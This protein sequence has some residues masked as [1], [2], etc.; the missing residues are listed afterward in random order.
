[1]EIKWYFKAYHRMITYGPPLIIIGLMFLIY[2][3]Y[4]IEYIL[5]LMRIDPRRRI[6]TN[7]YIANYY[8][9]N[10]SNVGLGLFVVLNWCFF[11]MIVSLTRTTFM[12][13]GY[14]PDPLNYEYNLVK[15]NLEFPNSTRM[16]TNRGNNFSSATKSPQTKKTLKKQNN[17]P[18]INRDSTDS[19]STAKDFTDHSSFNNTLTSE[20]GGFYQ[21]KVEKLEI[22]SLF[23]P[24]NVN[25]QKTN[26]IK[27]AKLTINDK[28]F[29]FIREFGQYTLEGPLTTTEFIRYR[30]NLEKYLVE[31]NP[32]N[33]NSI[34][35][36]QHIQIDDKY[37]HNFE[38]IYENFR[39]ID[40]TKLS[41]CMTCLRYKTERSHHCKACN[42]CVLKMDHHCPWLANCIAFANYKY[43]CLTIMY[44]FIASLIIFIT[45]WE[46]VIGVNMRYDSTIF[47]CSF[48]TF[49]YICN[50]SMMC[51]LSWLFYTNWNLIVNNVTTIER[52][53]KLR[54]GETSGITNFNKYDQGGF[55]NF[56][57]VFGRN[58]LFW[59]FPIKANNKGQGIIFEH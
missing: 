38:D 21:K 11:W 58:P 59:I 26:N 22:K 19:L 37:K 20:N 32:N 13:P 35:D 15:K 30:S 12:D 54:F 10:S 42:K 29:Q 8:P 51:F 23:N 16:S 45:M 39:N 2:G 43:F 41:L 50:F 3:T 44:G 34:I 53:D 27:K 4:L 14:I 55:K 18:L 48:I 57:A 56:A 52:A 6:Y 25:K 24:A 46:V 47:K 49:V 33:S 40:F 5:V 28:R 1:M 31:T 36:L 17:E 9:S 7:L